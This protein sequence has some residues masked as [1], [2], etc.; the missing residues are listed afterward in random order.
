MPRLAVPLSALLLASAGAGLVPRA[1]TSAGG[2]ADRSAIY[3]HSAPERPSGPVDL[4]AG[5]HLFLDDYLIESS[6]GLTRSAN[7]PPRDPALPNPIVTGKEDGCFQPYLSVVRDPER[8]VFRLWYGART[9][10][11]RGDASRLA[12][13]ESPDGIRWQRPHRLLPDPGPIQFG[14]SVLDEGPGYPDRAKRYKYAWWHGGGLRV[15]GSP[16]GFRFTPLAGDRVLLPHNHDING[17]FWDPIRKRYGAIAS[18]YEPGPK[19]KG[20]RRVTMQSVSPDLRQWQEPWLVLTPEDG[21]DPGETQFYAMDGILARGDLL[22]GMVKVLRDDL[23]ADT[24]PDPPEQYGI[25][26]TTLAWSRDGERWVRDREHF[27]DP[28]PK[29]GAWDHAH[30]W[31]DEQVPVGDQ[32]YLY[33]GGYARGHKVNRFEER[34]LGLVRMRRDRY[35]ARAAGETPGT[36]RTVV[37]VPR[38]DRLTLN[39]DAA[40][41]EVRARLLKP[42][43]TPLR[44]FT[45][46]DCRPI[47]SDSLDAPVRWKRPLAELKGKPVRLEL[48]MRSAKLY[49][50]SVK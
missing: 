2:R 19:W 48:Q 24:P 17:I 44:G 21:V 3:G 16:D 4:G 46:A 23:V 38:G 35:V 36:L 22:I 32:V 27:F 15:A 29:R 42:D 49:A 47:A 28:D 41:G 37:V 26:Y 20:Q 12:Y 14:V 11:R 18:T 33:Y 31:I 5:P 1:A 30:A 43:G 13:L 6:E 9:E 40:G 7:R 39:V 50:L 34:Q 45:Y 10:D 8:G 25:G